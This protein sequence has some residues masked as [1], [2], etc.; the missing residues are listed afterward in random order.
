MT[1]TEKITQFAVVLIA[2]SAVVVSVWQ[3]RISQKQLEIAQ[4]HN[5]LTVKPY[6]NITRFTNSDTKTFEVKISNQGYG[7][8]IIKKFELIYDGVSHGNWN[9]VLDA[10]NENEG[11]RFLNNYGSG[12]II[13]SG[14]EEVLVRLR[15][16]F[17]QKDITIKIAFESIY[18]E[19]DEIEFTF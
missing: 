11:I 7:P 10:A 17:D 4:E 9:S 6:L 5:R 2:I 19:P 12:S 1:R 3:G 18:E 8:A 16:T 13:A 15:T 14:K